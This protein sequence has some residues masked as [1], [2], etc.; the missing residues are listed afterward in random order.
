MQ[1]SADAIQP[2]APV[3]VVVGGTSMALFAVALGATVGGA[4]V[5][6]M[7]LALMA[8]VPFTRSARALR[9]GTGLAFG[10]FG[11]ELLG[12][13]PAANG[14]RLEGPYGGP[15]AVFAVASVVTALRAAGLRAE[16]TLRW[17]TRTWELP[18]AP[19]DLTLADT[20]ERALKSDVA[21]RAG[22][23]DCAVAA[24]ATARSEDIPEN[25][26]ERRAFW[27]NGY[28]LLSLHASRG[29]RSTWLI[30]VLEIYRTMYRIAGVALSLDEIEHG[31]L[32]SNSSAPGRLRPPLARGDTRL[33][34]QVSL[35]ARVHFAM[36]CGARSCPPVR[37]YRGD[38]LDAQLDLSMRAFVESDAELDREHGAIKV[39]RIFKWYSGDFGGVTGVRALI[40]D[41]LG[42]SQAELAPMKLIYRSYD[43][44]PPDAD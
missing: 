2:R 7:Y 17:A 34:W 18:S 33:A 31:L 41:T 29:R 4:F 20:V 37:V 44:R 12:L 8:L 16:S 11:W 1:S 40:A 32:R 5:F 26:R 10:A 25:E 35:D 23:V 42:I 30:D 13:A 19:E 38:Q 28:N 14:S 15:L 9:W 24:L 3:P 6:A 27:I 39:S 43:W 36:N 22:K 21:D